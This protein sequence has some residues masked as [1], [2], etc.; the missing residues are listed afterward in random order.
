MKN[1]KQLR[2][3]RKLSQHQLAEKLNLS[4]QTIYKYENN[5]TE[6]DI[7]TLI[8]LSAYFDTS[9]DYLIGNTNNPQKP[10]IYLE[11]ALNP[12]ELLHIRLYR[13]MPE[14]FQCLIDEIMIEYHNKE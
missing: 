13:C 7:D 5:I 11:T 2:L 3:D 8:K 9:V 4:Q 10:G 6:P 12:E 14:K 1:L